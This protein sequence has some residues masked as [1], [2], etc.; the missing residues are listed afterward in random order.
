[1]PRGPV[2]LSQVSPPVNGPEYMI[3]LK[4]VYSF[5]FS[6][7]IVFNFLLVDVMVVKDFFILSP[8]LCMREVL[9]FSF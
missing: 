7:K 4:Y 2:T 3:V 9:S 5:K 8:N 6:Q 1:M